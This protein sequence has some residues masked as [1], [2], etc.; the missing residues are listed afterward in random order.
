MTQSDGAMAVLKQTFTGTANQKNMP[1]I[2]KSADDAYNPIMGSY[3]QSAYETNRDAMVMDQDIKA[4]PVL[5]GWTGGQVVELPKKA[6]W[7][8]TP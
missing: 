3:D 1:T 8:F 6:P 7:P 5:K 4:T 2:L